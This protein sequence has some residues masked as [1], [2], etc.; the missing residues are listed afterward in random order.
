MNPN[1][2]KRHVPLHARAW[3][4]LQ[5]PSKIRITIGS[6]PVAVLIAGGHKRYRAAFTRVWLDE[7][8][9]K[10]RI[11]LALMTPTDVRDA[12]TVRRWLDRRH[13]Q[14]STIYGLPTD[15]VALCVAFCDAPYE[16][17]DAARVTGIP[18]WRPGFDSLAVTREVAP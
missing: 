17:I 14:A 16:L 12:D 2:S 11:G 4:D 3:H 13:V 8:S 18:V 7:L 9:G 5:P 6:A 10:L 15:P 1:P